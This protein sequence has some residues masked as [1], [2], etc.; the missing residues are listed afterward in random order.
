MNRRS[1]LQS[2]LYAG[3][4]AGCAAEA[5]GQTVHPA[6][7][8]YRRLQAALLKSRGLDYTT[9]LRAKRGLPV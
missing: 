4:A 1:F 6:V 3:I 2:I 8:R 5:A 9:W 7:E